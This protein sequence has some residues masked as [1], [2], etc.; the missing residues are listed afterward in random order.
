MK[1][2]NKKVMEKTRRLLIL[3]PYPRD[4]AGSQR[5]RFEQY[6][7]LWEANNI[8]VSHRSF[9]TEW[10][11]NIVYKKGVGLLKVVATLL[12]FCRR[13]SCLFTLKRYDLVFIHRETCPIGPAF[14]EWW[15]ARVAKKKIVYDFDDAIWISNTT[16]AWIHRLKNPGKTRKI[17]TWSSMIFVGNQ[18][19]ADFASQYNNSVIIIPTTIDTANHHN[20]TK[21]YPEEKDALCIGWTGSHSTLP[22]LTEIDGALNQIQNKYAV[23]IKIIANSR[24]ANLGVAFHFE[25]WD[26]QREIDQLL[27]I[28]IGIMPLPDKEWAQGKCAFKA[29]QYLSLEIPCIASPVGANKKV[30]LPNVNGFWAESEEEWVQALEMLLLDGPLRKKMG[31]AGRRHVEKNYSVSSQRDL[32][33][34]CI[35]HLML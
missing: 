23:Q 17:C 26:K 27:D 25:A 9:L 13:F 18:F 20:T 32:I 28:D 1:Q 34:E 33:L 21:E 15:I 12:G 16:N 6:I 10:G 3:C 7:P 5:F 2:S 14:F 24:P 29:L 19:L 35:S 31:K 8:E 22:Y 30:V 11:W 4:C